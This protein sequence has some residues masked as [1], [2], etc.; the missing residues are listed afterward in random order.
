MRREFGA[1]APAV[2]FEVMLDA[3]P[4]PR[5]KTG[6]ARPLLKLA[7]LQP[8]D[9]DFAFVV[10]RGVEADKLLRAVRGAGKDIAREAT[11]AS[12]SVFD[13]YEGKGIAEGKKSLALAVRLQPVERTLT[14]AEIEAIGQKL[15]AAVAKATGATLRS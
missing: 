6:R 12:V 2:A 8:V 9:R 5:A 13:I 7:T 15:V 11:I 1:D 4:P 10:D 3:L 14:D